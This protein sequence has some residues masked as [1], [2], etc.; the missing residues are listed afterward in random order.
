MIAGEHFW[1]LANKDHRRPFISPE[2]LVH[3]DIPTLAWFISLQQK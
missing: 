1:R 2:T 3:R